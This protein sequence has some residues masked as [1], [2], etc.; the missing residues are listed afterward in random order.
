MRDSESGGPSRLR[1]NKTAAL[2]VSLQVYENRRYFAL[3]IALQI[4]I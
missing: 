4:A 1:I 3:D 2:H